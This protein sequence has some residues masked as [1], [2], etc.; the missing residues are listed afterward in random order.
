M[1]TKERF[2]S[3]NFNQTSTFCLA[4]K[5]QYPAYLIV[6]LHANS[7]HALQL[8]SV[9]PTRSQISTMHIS[10]CVFLFHKQGKILINC[11]RQACGQESAGNGELS[12]QAT[13]CFDNRSSA[14]N[15]S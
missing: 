2:V 15:D 6:W 4:F 8:V 12:S 14:W 10:V 13:P 7:K 1:K 3:S 9:E 5:A 11:C